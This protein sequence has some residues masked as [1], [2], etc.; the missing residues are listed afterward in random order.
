MQIVVSIPQKY[1]TNTDFIHGDLKG[2]S[3]VS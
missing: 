1:M 2:D 3:S